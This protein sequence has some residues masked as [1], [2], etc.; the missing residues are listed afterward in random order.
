M[1]VPKRI[2]SRMTIVDTNPRLLDDQTYRSLGLLQNARILQL[3]E[4]MQC[5]GNIRLGICMDRVES[6]EINT[7]NQLLIEIHPAHLRW[8]FGENI[9]DEELPQYRSRLIREKLTA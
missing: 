4:A 2:D 3:E 1:F 7:I 5:L 9:N 6:I 8:K